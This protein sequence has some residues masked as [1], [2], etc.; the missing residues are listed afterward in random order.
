MNFAGRSFPQR[1]M[2][3][4]AIPTCA[5]LPSAE[6]HIKL[7]LPRAASLFRSHFA[8]D[9]LEQE[10]FWRPGASSSILLDESAFL[11][12]IYHVTQA[13]GLDLPRNL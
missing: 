8:L 3:I 6:P 10:G 4:T 9:C 5:L 7:L 11:G 1:Q 2:E 12:S 13:P